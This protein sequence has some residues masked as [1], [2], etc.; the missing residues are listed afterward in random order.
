MVFIDT[1]SHVLP[2][3]DDG[4]SDWNE[5]LAMLRQA[6]DDGIKHAVCT[7]HILS[8]ND[9]FKEDEW[10]TLLDEFK[11]RAERAGIAVELYLGAE[12]HIQPD[13]QLHRKISTLGQN[14]R[15]FLVEFPMNMIPDFVAKRFF[16]IIVSGKTPIIA[17]PERN[18]RVIQNIQI[19]YDFVAR[20]ALLQL[21]GGSLLGEFG[22]AVRQTAERLLDA[23]LIHVVGSDAHNSTNRPMLLSEAFAHVEARLGIARARELFYENPKRI[24]AGE[25]VTVQPPIPIE[26]LGPS[27]RSKTRGLLQW[28]NRKG[29]SR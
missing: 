18:G 28:F 9:F 11:E 6:E 12:I 4:S 7:P 2:F 22:D 21:N 16:E 3:I 20:G 26:E 15:Y 14:G 19:A 10:F 29:Q 23:D 27:R 8:P 1:H 25:V 24:L 5:S 17:H 13:L